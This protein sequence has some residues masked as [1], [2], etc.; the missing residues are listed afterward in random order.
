M[1]WYAVWDWLQN[2]MKS[3]EAD[4]DKIETRQAMSWQLLNWVMGH[5]SHDYNTAMISLYTCGGFPTLTQKRNCRAYTSFKFYWV[6]SNCS[7]KRLHK[8]PFSL[9]VR[10]TKTWGFP[11][12][13]IGLLENSILPLCFH[14]H[15]SNHLKHL[16]AFAGSTELSLCELTV[17]IVPES[18]LSFSL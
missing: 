11:F 4:G 2:N 8:F 14:L 6:V 18:S 12:L 10:L 17:H 9:I 13:S 5:G 7:P 3:V 16:S 15:Y 1:K